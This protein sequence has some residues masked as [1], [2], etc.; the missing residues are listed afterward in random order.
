[1]GYFEVLEKHTLCDG[2]GFWRHQ[3]PGDVTSYVQWT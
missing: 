1:M 3:I 2:D